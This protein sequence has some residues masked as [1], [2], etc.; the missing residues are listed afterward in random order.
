[1]LKRIF[2][3]LAVAAAALSSAQAATHLGLA[4]TSSHVTLMSY[5]YSGRYNGCN[6]PAWPSAVDFYRVMENGVLDTT[7][8]FAVPD[9]KTL[10]VTDVEWV[11]RGGLQ[12]P[13]TPFAANRPLRLDLRVKSN[14]TPHPTKVYSSARVIVTPALVN[15]FLGETDHLTAGFVVGPGA[16]ICPQA[17]QRTNSSQTFV[18]LETVILHGYLFP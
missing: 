18:Y 5:G 17:Y 10:V 15:E 11:A 7:A 13:L 4:S 2:L 9:G 6:S 3:G 12:G 1:M 16:K 8:P 14:E